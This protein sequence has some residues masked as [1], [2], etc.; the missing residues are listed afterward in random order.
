MSDNVNKM[1]GE[2]FNDMADILEGRSTG[3]KVRVGITTFGSEHGVENV[4]KGAEMAQKSDKTVEVILIGPKV[5]SS[6]IQEAVKDEEE[7]Y[8]KMEELL[9]SGKIDCAVTMHYSFPVGVSTVGRT[10]S[11]GTGKEIFIATTT[12]TSSSHRVEAMIKNGILGII[13]AKSM[14]IEDPKVGILNVD[15]ANQVER[16]L[17]RLNSNGYKINFAESMRADGGCIMRGNDLLTGS[18]DVI[19]TDTLT[20]NILSKLFSSFTTGGSYESLGYGYGPS[21]GEGYDRKILIISRASGAPVVKNAI[22]YGKNIIDGEIRKKQEEEFSRANNAGLKEIL[23]DVTKD[24][25]KE[26]KNE[27]EEVQ[28]PSKE[29]VTGSIAGI[30]IMELENAVKVLWKNGVYAESG[31]GCT[32]PILMVNEEKLPKAVNILS[33]E[34]YISRE[35]NIQC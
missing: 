21:I 8:K 19:V 12:G 5:D 1:I 4:V 15:G 34:G 7:G 2:I 24:T 9:D 22:L 18:A 30:D 31:M 27:Y 26:D 35:S 3:K 14:G 6:L 11:P 17:E 33:K 25:K 32:G 20:G 29:V 13:A 28:A 23:K 16:A 10:V